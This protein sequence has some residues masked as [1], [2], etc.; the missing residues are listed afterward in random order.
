VTRF[1]LR[2]LRLLPG[3]EHRVRLD[4]ELEPFDLGGQSYAVSP[5]VVDAELTVQRATSGLVF[6]LRFA[7]DAR[8]PCMRC[9]DDAVVHLSVDVLEYH[10]AEAHGDEELRSDYVADDQLALSSWARDSVA[11]GLPDPILCRSDCAGLCP[12][13]G[14][15][16]NVE[17]HAHEEATIDPRWGALD[18][19]AREVREDR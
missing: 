4:V 8:G 3:E 9:L 11:L 19:L 2:S 10:D 7:V 1:P 14:K 17:P 15:N 13:C 18:A 5:E 12:A 16:L 6:R